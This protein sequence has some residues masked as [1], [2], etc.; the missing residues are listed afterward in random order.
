MRQALVLG[1]GG[2]VGVAWETGVVAGMLDAGVDLRAAE[3]IVGTSAGSIVGTRIAAGQDLRI[4]A[5]R[6]A[7]AIPA[8]EGG[9]DMATL[10][11][12][13]GRWVAIETIDIDFLKEIGA[14]AAAARTITEDDFIAATGGSVGVDDWPHERL[15]LIAVDVATG[16]LAVHD[17]ASGAPL[18]RAIAAS[19]A[20]PGLF[21]PIAI[22][23]RRFMDGGVRSCTSADVLA[24]H[25]PELTVII[26]P[27]AKGT[28]GFGALAERCIDEEIAIL[29][30]AGSACV[31]IVPDADDL[32]A[33]GPNLMDPEQAMPARTRGEARGR[34]LADALRDRWR[35]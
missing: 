3:A 9:P 8:L 17:R 22:G 11:K 35:S 18:H 2:V 21:P 29:D 27:I 26:A 20:V 16:A 5:P 12:V 28:G 1:G 34:A 15:S 14:L 32:A 4:D 6:T 33:L 13:F 31:K 24:A 23:A 30:R 7:V 10:G 25:R 19:C